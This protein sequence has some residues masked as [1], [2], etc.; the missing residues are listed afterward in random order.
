MSGFLVDTNVLSE[1][2]R[3]VPDVRVGAWAQVVSKQSLFLSVVSF[4]EIR[5]GLTIMP[6][7]ARRNQLAS[8]IEDLIP[9]WFAGRILSITQSIAE[10]W[11]ILEGSRH[12]A[13]RL[14]HV[15]D[16]QIAATALEHGLTLV[17]RNVKDFD[18]LG[19]TILNPWDE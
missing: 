15:P 1:I 3:P 11:G 19:V 14:L 16:A 9:A 13:G 18:L 17:T 10:R 6:P 5:K 7:G 12:L 2:L 8:S 4:G